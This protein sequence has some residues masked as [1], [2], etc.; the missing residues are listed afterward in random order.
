MFLEILQNSQEDTCVS[1]LSLF[2]NKVAGLRSATLF[3]KIFRRRSLLWVFNFLRTPFLQNTSRRLLLTPGICL[4]LSSHIHN[5]VKKIIWSV[6]IIWK[7]QQLNTDNYFCKK[8]HVIYFIVF[9]MR[10]QL[11]SLKTSLFLLLF[12][13]LWINKFQNRSFTD[14]L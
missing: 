2:F 4:V 10:L 14:A 13:P 8:L 1:S 7:S 12:L 6:L 5:P 11:S 9:W 3:K